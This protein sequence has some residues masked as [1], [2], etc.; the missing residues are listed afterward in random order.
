MYIMHGW[1]L[2]AVAQCYYR[3]GCP[4]AHF[5]WPDPIWLARFQT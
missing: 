3:Q 2:A 4:W 1:M 5:S